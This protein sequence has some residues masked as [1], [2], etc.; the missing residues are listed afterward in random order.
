[1]KPVQLQALEAIKKMCEEITLENNYLTGVREVNVGDVPMEV[2]K[3]FPAININAGGTTYLNPI[4][5]EAGKLMKTF[6]VLI[7]AF[8]TETEPRV[9]EE[10]L[11]NI[12]ADLETRFADDTIDG[13][14]T[15]NQTK[16]AFNLE[17]TVLI[18]Q[19]ISAE[20]FDLES[21]KDTL[22]VAF[23][24]EIKIRQRRN[25]NSQNY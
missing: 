6:N 24:L 17:N 21:Y 18:C 11:I 8:I 3:Q 16:T 10:K 7:E 1:M 5:N 2:I 25:D 13:N 22:G 9:R 15:Y 20:I 23:Q 4:Q 19:P 14:P 12:I